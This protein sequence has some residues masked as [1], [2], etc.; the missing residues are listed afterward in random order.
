MSKEEQARHFLPVPS[1]AEVEGVAFQKQGW[2]E[3]AWWTG[4]HLEELNCL[5]E[6]ALANNPNLQAAEERILLSK[7]ENIIA[8]AKLFPLVSFDASDDWSYLSKTGLYR[9]LN[10]TIPLN[11]QVIDLNLSFSYEFD[12]WG[13]YRNLYKAAIG[14]YKAQIAE[15]A[16]VSLILSAAVAQTYFALKTNMWRQKVYQELYEVR[17]H[18]FDLQTELLDHSILSKLPPLLSEEAVFEAKQWLD[19]IEQE[20]AV[21]KHLLNT[22]CGQGPDTALEV[23]SDPLPENGA[24][25]IPSSISTEL[26]SRRPDLM[27]QIWRVEALAKEVGAAKANFWPNVNLVGLLGFQTTS[28]SELLHWASKTIEG[29]PG[30]TLPIYTAG[31]ISAEVNAKKA[32][33][34]TAVYTYNDLLLKSFQQVSDLIALG[35]SVYDKKEQQRSIVKNASSRYLLTEL[36]RD[37]KID[38]ALDSLEKQDAL[39]QQTL[40]DIELIFEQYAISVQLTRAL[41]G[42]YIAK[43][44]PPL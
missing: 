18:Y 43:E 4:Y 41:G 39:L 3:A 15:A 9:A 28:W 29:I 36:R 13:K 33:F 17:K 11:A 5:V 35:R 23:S 24:L 21:D 34:N 40:K 8:R 42:G 20:I 1:L 38:N 27:A 14:R 22:L 16:Q 37:Q 26:L 6:K 19:T 7:N 32:E 10:P 30:F 44:E 25:L 12:F 2:P 31:R